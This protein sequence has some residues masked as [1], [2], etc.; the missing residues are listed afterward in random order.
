[1]RILFIVPYAPT[2]IRVRPYQFIRALRGLGHSLTV[3]TLI[4]SPEDAQAVEALRADGVTVIAERL[5]PLRKVFNLARA[6]PSPDPLQTWFSWSPKLAAEILRAA[7]DADVAHVEHLRGARYGLALRRRIPTVWDSVDCITHLFEQAAAHRNSLSGRMVSAIELGRTRAAEGHLVSQFDQVTLTSDR[8][9]DA[10]LSLAPGR[11]APVTVIP[12]G[13]DL[14][15]FSPAQQPFGGPPTLVFSGKMSYHANIA[16]ACFLVEQVMPRVWVGCPEARLVIAG[17]RPTAVVQAFAAAH[18]GRVTVTGYVADLPAVLRTATVAVAPLVYGAGI[19][20]KVLEAMACGL[21]VVTNAR[22]V[23]ALDGAQDGENCMI[24]ESPEALADK[25]L[26]LLGDVRLRARLGAA[27]R[28]YVEAYH[29]WSDAARQL[30]A[31]YDA[32]MARA[33]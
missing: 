32:A 23:S 26:T 8:D 4:E 20:N 27:G 11:A 18:P 29:R 24:A 25:I 28:A 19:Q 16:A 1:M 14:E 33:G 22:A 3:A 15:A 9:R 5:S 31:V 17:S 21:P 6:L 2:K 13:V 30:E 7:A 10:L 12:N